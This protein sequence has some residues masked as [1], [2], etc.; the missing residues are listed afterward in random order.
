MQQIYTK[1]SQHILQT[2]VKKAK[3]VPLVTAVCLTVAGAFS[4][5]SILGTTLHQ[6]YLLEQQQLSSM[7]V[8]PE[9]KYIEALLY[10]NIRSLLCIFVGVSS[11]RYRPLTFHFR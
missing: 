4:F 6:I 3:F 11:D 1:H 9:E 10:S 8:L 5:S 7:S 2:S